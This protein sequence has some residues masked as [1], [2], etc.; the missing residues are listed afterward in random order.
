MTDKQ[1]E[2]Y[3]IYSALVNYFPGYHDKG[4][5]LVPTKEEI[6]MQRERLKKDIQDFKPEIL[7]T[8]GKLSLSYCLDRK[9]ESLDGNYIGRSFMIDPYGMLDRKVLVIPFPHPSG[10]STWK[11]KKGNNELLQKALG[12]FKTNLLML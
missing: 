7:V 4:G 8:I 1:I 10:A 6:S 12:L 3:S 11:Y 2:E 5:H 9:I